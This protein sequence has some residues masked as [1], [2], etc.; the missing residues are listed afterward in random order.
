M[1]KKD[2]LKNFHSIQSSVFYYLE[3]LIDQVF[4]K[5]RFVQIDGQ[6]L[7]L[8]T[9]TVPISDLDSIFFFASFGFANWKLAHQNKQN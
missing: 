9:S 2:F 7:M 4:L 5:N 3:F 1:K 6:N 8:K